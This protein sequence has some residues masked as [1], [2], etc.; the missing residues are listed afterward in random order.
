[1]EA[2]RRF[3]VGG[4]FAP[5][6]LEVLLKIGIAGAREELTVDHAQDL[7]VILDHPR[8]VRTGERVA[9]E[10]DQLGQ[11]RRGLDAK[12]L[13]RGR[14]QRRH[15]DALPELHR[16]LEALA[17]LL[18]EHLSELA[19]LRVP[20]LLGSVGGR[21]DLVLVD[22][23]DDAKDLGV[24][25]PF[26]AAHGLSVAARRWLWRARDDGLVGIGRTPRRRIELKGRHVGGM[27]APSEF[28]FDV[29]ERL[30]RLVHILFAGH[31]V[32]NEVEREDVR[33]LLVAARRDLAG[34]PIDQDAAV[35][36][37]ELI[38]LV[39]R[40][41]VAN[42]LHDVVHVRLGEGVRDLLAH[43]D[44]AH[45]GAVVVPDEPRRRGLLGPTVL[46]DRPVG[47]ELRAR[48][49]LRE[50]PLDIGVIDRTGR[51]E[52]RPALLR[53]CRAERDGRE[54]E[55]HARH[56]CAASLHEKNSTRVGCRFPIEGVLYALPPEPGPSM[57]DL[58]HADPRVVSAIGPLR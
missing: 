36:G 44:G 3:E 6:G 20:S 58:T 19:D 40:H 56:D 34:R 32:V 29:A 5:R 15:V 53:S 12:L 52:L 57:N 28:H 25:H 26:S 51:G 2:L 38:G 11:L 50:D 18:V 13:D 23:N 8:N 49:P 31:D 37:D 47:R 41:V 55:E 30:A 46:V 14:L 21:F 39:G 42:R 9:F 16:R 22:G 17:V 7:R 35:E 24:A 54:G 48:R 43:H 33:L 10:P 1:M 4:D 27:I 45:P